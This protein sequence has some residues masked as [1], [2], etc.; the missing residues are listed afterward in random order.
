MTTQTCL[1]CKWFYGSRGVWDVPAALMAHCLIWSRDV[2]PDSTCSNWELPTPY[3]P[4]PTY[5]T[6]EGGEE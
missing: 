1:G 5:E 6:P 4:R 3:V 2:L